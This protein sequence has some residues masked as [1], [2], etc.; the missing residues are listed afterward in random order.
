MKIV[1][2]GREVVASVGSVV[3]EFANAKGKCRME[4]TG[5]ALV[6]G[7]DRWELFGPFSTYD[8]P[9]TEAEMLAFLAD[10]IDPDPAPRVLRLSTGTFDLEAKFKVAGVGGDVA[11]HR[12]YK[13]AGDGVYWGL[14]SGAILKAYYSDADRAHSARMNGE[15][16]VKNGEVVTIGGA[17]YRARVLG[18]YS[19][20]CIFDPVEVK[21]YSMGSVGFGDFLKDA[22]HSEFC[23][24]SSPVGEY[25]VR[26]A[27]G[28]RLVYWYNGAK[29]TYI[30][31][32]LSQACTAT[33]EWFGS[34]EVLS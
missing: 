26:L 31:R 23:A 21:Q 10:K 24:Y 11:L 1:V 20:C 16:P 4:I 17:D 32:P 34:G 7:S 3:G 9:K 14:Q 18:N 15:V 8:E 29:R 28:D 30:P 13:V 6:P 2:N 22:G 19:D 25:A 5:A 33:L 12:D 27:S